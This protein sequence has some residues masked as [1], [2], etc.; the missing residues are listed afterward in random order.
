MDNSNKVKITWRDSQNVA[1]LNEEAK[2][3]ALTLSQQNTVNINSLFASEN[4]S[5]IETG[6]K[7]LNELSSKCWLLSALALY[8]LVYNKKM[9]EQSNLTWQ[10]YTKESKQR[11]GMNDREISEQ[12]SSARFFVAHYKELEKAEWSPVGS[13]FKLAR[14]EL[15]YLLS[16]DLDLTIKHLKE[17]S[18]REFKAWY[19][20]MKATPVITDNNSL[21]RDDIEIDGNIYIVNKQKAVTISDK[22]SKEEQDK[23]KTYLDRIFLTLKSGYEPAIIPVK[24]KEDANKLL[25]LKKDL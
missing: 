7:S 13:S 5:D 1:E 19:Q 24:D 15:A 11:L 14:A 20:S 16:N 23:L 25:N 17:D 3:L 10:Q 4:L 6:I 9:Y 22:L 18:A 12:L 2:T 21:K 8:S